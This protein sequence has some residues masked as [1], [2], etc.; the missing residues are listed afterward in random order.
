MKT[1][2]DHTASSATTYARRAARGDGDAEH[3]KGREGAAGTS[4]AVESV[5]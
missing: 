1:V 4:A 2:D 3:E 5:T